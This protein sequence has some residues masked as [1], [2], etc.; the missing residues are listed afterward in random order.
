MSVKMQRY[1]FIDFDNL[2][3]VKFK[4]LEK[5][6]DKL[7]ILI[8]VNEKSIPFSLVMNIQRLGKGVKWIVVDRQTS[9]NLSQ[10]ISFVMGRLH[11]KV[12]KTIEFAI[13][14]NDKSFDSLVNFI[15]TSG[16]SCL[17]VKR[18]NSKSTQK[19]LPAEVEE[20]ELVI[21]LS[22][23]RPKGKKTDNEQLPFM[24]DRAIEDEL[25]VDT[26][27]ETIE[28][29]KYSGNRPAKVLM[30]RDYILLHNQ[31]LTKDG[32]ADQIIDVLIEKK[33]IEI[34]RGEVKYNF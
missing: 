18:K 29:L 12:D 28:R 3:K 32:N 27:M 4:K 1:V 25:I 16:R 34:E 10:H 8:D 24:I 26:A 19:E 20:T 7:F 6:C 30:L 33:E 11:Q 15:N 23:D 13:L 2:K 14:S 9:E 21:N 5:V 31:E 22:N 17:R